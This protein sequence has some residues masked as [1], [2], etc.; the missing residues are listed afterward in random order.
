MHTRH[1]HA[2]CFIDSGH[3]KG[4]ALPVKFSLHYRALVSFQPCRV[5]GPALQVYGPH[6]LG[7]RET[8]GRKE[9][10]TEQREVGEACIMYC[11]MVRSHHRTGC[12]E[13]EQFYNPH[14]LRAF[15]GWYLALSTVLFIKHQG[16][17]KHGNEGEGGSILV[18]EQL[19]FNIPLTE[20]TQ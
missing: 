9:R 12:S 19:L 20:R 15:I 4:R 13:M 8:G 16:M 3:N 11:R 14:Y 18:E 10:R 7:Q 2:K 5:T 17:F 1:M 6:K